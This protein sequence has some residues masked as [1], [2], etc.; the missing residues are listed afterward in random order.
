[1]IE[2]ARRQQDDRR[3]RV[4]PRL[5]PRLKVGAAHAFDVVRAAVGARRR[6]APAGRRNASRDRSPVAVTTSTVGRALA[7]STRYRALSA[8]TPVVVDGH[9]APS[10]RAARRTSRRPIPAAPTGIVVSAAFA[11]ADE[12]ST[13]A[14]TLST[15]VGLTCLRSGVAHR[16]HDAIVHDARRT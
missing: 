14:F 1:M 4:E 8:A 12:L 16:R 6:G 3:V 15:D 2:A 7:S 13:A 10:G 9:R 11:V 5:I